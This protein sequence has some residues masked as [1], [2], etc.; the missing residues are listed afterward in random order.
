MIDVDV[1]IDHV[2]ENNDIDQDHNDCD[3]ILL[4]FTIFI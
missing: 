3:D 4:Y 1:M 2:D